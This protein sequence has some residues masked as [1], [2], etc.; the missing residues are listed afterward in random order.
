MTN[1]KNYA[2]GSNFLNAECNSPPSKGR[3]HDARCKHRVDV[4]EA[5]PTTLVVAKNEA[6]LQMRKKYHHRLEL[7]SAGAF[8]RQHTSKSESLR[9]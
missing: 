1:H 9:S 5:L 4:A 8:V 7:T 2:T 6:H 3:I